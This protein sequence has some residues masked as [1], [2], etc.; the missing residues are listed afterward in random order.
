MSF[1]SELN[2]KILIEI[3]P[4]NVLEARQ[5]LFI[6]TGCPPTSSKAP[7]V[8]FKQPKTYYQAEKAFFRF[9]DSELAMRFKLMGF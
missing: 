6:E 7:F 2:F 3:K 5:W 9:R 4:N 1:S 8:Y